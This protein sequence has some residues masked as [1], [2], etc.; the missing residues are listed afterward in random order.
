MS[1]IFSGNIF[2]FHAFDVGEDIDLQAIEK[3]QA[4][5]KVP[6]NQPKYFKD[7]HIPLS[8]ELPHPHDTSTWLSCKLHSFGAIT[9]TYKVPFTESL[10]E[11]RGDIEELEK[12]YQEQ[13]ISD[14]GVI[15][16]KIKQYIKQPKFFHLQTSYPVIQVDPESGLNSEKLKSEY[17]S[18]IAALLIFETQSLSKYQVKEI[19]ESSLD[20]YRGDLIVI[21]TEAAFVSDPDYE[22]ILD[23]FEFAN[24]QQLQLRYFDKTLNNQLNQIYERKIRPLT[25]KSYLPF[26]GTH[27]D[28]VLDLG[29]LRVDI[30]VIV[31]RLQSSI[32]LVD[33]AYYSDIY[34]LLEQKLDIK[35][36]QESVDK[37]LEIIKD[38]RGV[39]SHQVDVTK[40]D[41]LTVLIIILIFIELIVGIL[42]YLK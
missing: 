2:F 18:D 15:F 38:V 7:Y 28:G 37:K 30:S 11:L 13:S 1:K 39:Y 42:S 14:L 26:I 29:R 31:E 32:K 27:N 4:L 12:K 40:E 22:E 24:M 36:L 17:G 34:E 23:L 19:M 9:L 20:Y 21:G 41:I 3:N 25:I 6:S 33:E 10:T 8:V 35:Q 16:K 5:I